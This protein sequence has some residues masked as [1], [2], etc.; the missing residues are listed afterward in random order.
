MNKLNKPRAFAASEKSIM[1]TFGTE[2]REVTNLTRS[3]LLIQTVVLVADGGKWHEIEVSDLALDSVHLPSFKHHVE[4]NEL[5]LSDLGITEEEPL[6]SYELNH[7]DF[8]SFQEQFLAY[9]YVDIQRLHRF[10]NSKGNPSSRSHLKKVLQEL[11][12]MSINE[13]MGVEIVP[14]RDA[15]DETAVDATKEQLAI[16]CDTVP[17]PVPVLVPVDSVSL[18]LFEKLTPE[19]ITELQGLRIQQEKI[20]TENPVIVIKDKKTYMEAKKTAA[21]FNLFTPINI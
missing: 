6:T 12:G 19:K 16:A 5:T 11:N 21:L 10:E 8:V 13:W 18:S 14:E 17:V 4:T 9:N 7:N 1:V 3:A 2:E 15:F 20:V